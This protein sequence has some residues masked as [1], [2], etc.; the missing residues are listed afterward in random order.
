MSIFIT[1]PCGH[2]I[3]SRKGDEHGPIVRMLEHRK[4]DHRWRPVTSPPTAR[5]TRIP[6]TR[7]VCGGQINF[8]R[9]GQWCDRCG[10]NYRSIAGVCACGHG[11]GTHRSDGCQSCGCV[12]YQEAA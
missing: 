4:N 5:A 10:G 9:L 7:C 6:R 1:C 12:R 11:S 8:D 3:E 2:V